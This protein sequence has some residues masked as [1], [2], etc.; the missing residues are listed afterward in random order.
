MR[1]PRPADGAPKPGRRGNPDFG[2]VAVAEE[3]GDLAG[4]ALGGF[5]FLVGFALGLGRRNED[6]FEP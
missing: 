5:D 1:F 4:A 6:A 2:D 3:P